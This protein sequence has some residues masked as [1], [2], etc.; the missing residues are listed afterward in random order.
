MDLTS[1]LLC[2]DAQ[3]V[4]DLKAHPEFGCVSEP[5]RKAKRG[6][7][8][9]AALSLNDLCDSVWWNAKLARQVGWEYPDRS[10]LTGQDLAR[11]CRCRHSC[12][13][14]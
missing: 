9:D 13:P 10:E 8:G 7:A 11:M 1:G 4:L 14:R 2:G 12:A 5:V 3:L 6:V